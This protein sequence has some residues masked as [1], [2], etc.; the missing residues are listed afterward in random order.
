MNTLAHRNALN[1]IG[2][3]NF[4]KK[5]LA[6]ALAALDGL[7]KLYVANK[8]TRHEFISCITPSHASDMTKRERKQCRVWKAWDKAVKV[9][10]TA[11][12]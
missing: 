9:I 1:L 4:T 2:D 8:G 7:V 5:R 10:D 6:E 12:A 3:M 11:K